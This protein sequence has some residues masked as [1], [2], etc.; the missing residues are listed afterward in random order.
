MKKLATIIVL[1]LYF[2]VSTG[3][4]LS[5]H[6]CM[7]VI[8]AVEFG[9]A[10][11]DVC[12]TCGMP[13]TGNDGCCKDEVKLLKIQADQLVSQL[14]NADFS[15]QAIP[16]AHTLFLFTP[17]YSKI[18]KTEPFAHGP[19]LSKQDTYLQNRVFRI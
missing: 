6:Y 1:L 7:D 13:I 12:N 11:E 8:N 3:F 17:L 2:V 5:F 4:V 19:P 18:E 15:L 14:V 10:D 16:V 9:H